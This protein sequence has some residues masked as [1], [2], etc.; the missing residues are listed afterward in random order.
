MAE[1]I[2]GKHFKVYVGRNLAR[3]L[4]PLFVVLDAVRK[5]RG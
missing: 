2:V 1:R 3:F 5:E 4:K